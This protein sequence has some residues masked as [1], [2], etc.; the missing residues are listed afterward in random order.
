VPGALQEQDH[1]ARERRSVVLGGVI[2]LGLVA[3]LPRLAQRR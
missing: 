3:L 1:R 2:L